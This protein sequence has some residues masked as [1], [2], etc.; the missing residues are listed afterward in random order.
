MVRGNGSDLVPLLLYSGNGIRQ[1]NTGTQ[2][3]TT[4]AARDR[5]TSP[6]AGARLVLRPNSYGPFQHFIPTF[7]RFSWTDP[8]SSEFTAAL[9]QDLWAERHDRRAAQCPHTGAHDDI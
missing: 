4:L 3:I 5:E 7:R 6:R 9:L 8:L 1:S 2:L